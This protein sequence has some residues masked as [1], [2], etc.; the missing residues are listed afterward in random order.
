MESRAVWE[1]CRGRQFSQPTCRDAIARTAALIDSGQATLYTP[2][3][4]WQRRRVGDDHFGHRRLYHLMKAGGCRLGEAASRPCGVIATPRAAAVW[5]S[6]SSVASGWASQPNTSVWTKVTPVKALT[7]CTPP[8]ARGPVGC[9]AQHAWHRRRH[10][11]YRLQ[12]RIR[13]HV[14]G[15]LSVPGARAA[16]IIRGHGGCG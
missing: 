13:D 8:V 7:R 2:V 14:S 9:R 11:C 1:E 12:S 15:K 6:W 10:L 3:Q 16:D 4:Q 5:Q